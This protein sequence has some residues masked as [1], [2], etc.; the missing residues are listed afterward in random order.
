MKS[1]TWEDRLGVCRG[2]LSSFWLSPFCERLLIYE[3]E[4]TF[5]SRSCE[6]S[7]TLSLCLAI[8]TWVCKLDTP[9]VV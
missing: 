7:L 8:R 4:S 1:L 6:G 9:L 3:A 5:C 2:Y